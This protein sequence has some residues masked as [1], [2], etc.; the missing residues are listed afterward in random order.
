MKQKETAFLAQLDRVEAI[1]PVIERSGGLSRAS[2][3]TS[4]APRSDEKYGLLLPTAL[5]VVATST[6]GSSWIGVRPSRATW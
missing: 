1:D 3:K 5:R 4:S 6:T 2:A